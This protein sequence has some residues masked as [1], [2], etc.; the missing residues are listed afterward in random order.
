MTQH[1]HEHPVAGGSAV[2]V[3]MTTR[4]QGDLRLGQPADVLE[5]RRRSVVDLPWSTL[6]QVHGRSLLEVETPG[7][8]AGRE[9][10][11]LLT[12]LVGAAIAVQVADCAP[13]ALI[14]ESGSFAVVHAGWRGLRAGVIDAAVDALEARQAGPTVAVLGACIHAECYEFGAAELASI[15]S[16]W[17]AE[18]VGRTS[19]GT[20]A[21]D[22]PALVSLAL[23]RRGVELVA[24]IGG[25]TACDELRWYSHRARTD[26]GRQAMVAWR[27]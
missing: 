18:V 14:A 22:V 7:E 24:R 12:D 23:E 19:W 6:D 1:Y 13:V 15:E 20:P 5:R 8:G 3:L 21:L 10:D 16:E 25:C 2:Q 26:A 9:G 27:A 17:G 11:A 4:A